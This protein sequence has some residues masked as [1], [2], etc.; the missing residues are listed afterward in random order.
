[1]L[2]STIA[3]NLVLLLTVL[4]STSF[5]FVYALDADQAAGLLRIGSGLEQRVSC[6]AP[7]WGPYTCAAAADAADSPCCVCVVVTPSTSHGGAIPG[8]LNPSTSTCECITPE[9]SIAK[10][11]FL[12]DGVESVSSQAAPRAGIPLASWVRIARSLL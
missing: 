9:S 2:S 3:Q 11:L 7:S 1:M 12:S 8:C 10:E 5:A 4:L 6:S